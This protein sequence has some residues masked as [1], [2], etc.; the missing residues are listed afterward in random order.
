MREQGIEARYLFGVDDFDPVDEIPKG[1]DEHFGKY[2]GWPLCNTPA[3]RGGSL[4]E[5]AVAPLVATDMAEYYMAEFWQVFEEL[6]VK[7]ERYR[8]RD[9]YR[10]GQFNE[11]IDR[12]LQQRSKGASRLPRGIA[13]RAAE[14]WHPFQVICEKCG[15]IATTEVSSYESGEV[16]YRCLPARS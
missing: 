1:E 15:C 9:I 13:K 11:P 16:V 3:P 14:H 2:I 6:G 12:I 5:T 10:G 4:P 8:M 7:V